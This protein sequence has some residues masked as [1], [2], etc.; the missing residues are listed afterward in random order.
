M[1]T[2]SR[3]EAGKKLEQYWNSIASGD[4]SIPLRSAF[5]LSSATAPILPYTVIFEVCE[6]DLVFRLAGTGI[7][8]HQGIDITGRRYGE[9]AAPDQVVRAIARVKACHALPCGF[10]SVHREEY[11][12]GDASE[13]EV[14]GL[15]L[16]GDEEG[17]EMMVLVVTPIE[18]G[19]SAR[20][21]E[22]LFMRPASRIEFIDL[23]S[24]TPDDAAIIATLQKQ[25]PHR[26]EGAP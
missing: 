7:A 2:G 13:V 16:R 11:G 6:G 5:K 10:V 24:G 20:R 4:G 3:A 25:Q 17:G 18:R 9:F 21:A 8:A 1:S 22:P 23:G 12:R 14:T 26:T 19:L 15:P